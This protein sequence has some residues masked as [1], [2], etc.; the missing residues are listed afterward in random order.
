METLTVLM[1]LSL[2]VRAFTHDVMW[3]ALT[4]THVI[5][6]VGQKLFQ[7]QTNELEMCGMLWNARLSQG[8]NSLEIIC[9]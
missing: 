4:D 6:L 5:L 7:C 9:N 1:A 8:G 2:F 3:N